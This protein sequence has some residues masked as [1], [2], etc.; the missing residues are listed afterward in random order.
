MKKKSRF[1]NIAPIISWAMMV[2]GVLDNPQA[3]E[4]GVQDVGKLEERLG[5]LREYR[6]QIASWKRCCEII[7]WSLAWINRQGIESHSGHLLDHHLNQLRKHRCELSDRMQEQ[8]VAFVTTSASQLK[9]GER[10]WLSTE[11]LESAFGLF[12]R[13]EGQQSRSGFTGLLASLPTLLRSW[14]AVEVRAALRRTGMKAM[15]EWVTVN[16]GTTLWAKRAQ[17]FQRFGDPK[18][19]VFP[20]T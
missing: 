7:G 9:D 6:D 15:T 20:A 16:I 11:T 12:K 4:S 17:A 14:T 1:M 3:I 18:C 19:H 5:W 10:C 13:R 2:L 8:L